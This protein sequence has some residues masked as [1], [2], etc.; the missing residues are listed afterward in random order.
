MDKHIVSTERFEAIL[1]VAHK[2]GWAERAVTVLDADLNKTKCL[3]PPETFL[4]VEDAY[5]VT[6]LRIDE[7]GFISEVVTHG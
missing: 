5:D 6:I 7:N 3:F 2:G 1:K 4:V